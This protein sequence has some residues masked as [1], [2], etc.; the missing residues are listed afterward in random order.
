MRGLV[1]GLGSGCTDCPLTSGIPYGILRARLETA[2]HLAT[3]M[4]RIADQLNQLIKQMEE[5][6]RRLRYLVDEHVIANP[7][8]H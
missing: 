1:E 4:G 8:G 3:I 7:Q 6:D 2:A 5:S